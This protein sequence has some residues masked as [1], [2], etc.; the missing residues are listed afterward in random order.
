MPIIDALATEPSDMLIASR[1]LNSR[2]KNVRFIRR[3]SKIV[4]AGLS[5]KN[6]N[7]WDVRNLRL[8]F[9]SRLVD[10]LWPVVA[11]SRNS[12]KQLFQHFY[13]NYTLTLY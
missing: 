1:Q 12:V 4:L 6:G 11:C 7:Q 9:S 2:T 13:L 8:K 3:I 5:I 10:I